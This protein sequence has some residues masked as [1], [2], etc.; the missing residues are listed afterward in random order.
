[1]RMS[2]VQWEVQWTWSLRSRLADQCW[3]SH[4]RKSEVF[5]HKD[6][7]A[8]I[9]RKRAVNSSLVS[10]ISNSV[11]EHKRIPF[12]NLPEMSV[13]RHYLIYSFGKLNRMPQSPHNLLT[14][15]SGYVLCMFQIIGYLVVIS[16]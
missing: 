14:C 12:L 10:N 6:V 2:E 1:M 13:G 16:I 3:S 9:A 4:M 7:P 15:C 5:V 8:S 11:A